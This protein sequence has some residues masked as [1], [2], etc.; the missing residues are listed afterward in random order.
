MI[1]P[2]DIV[3]SINA[4]DY[5]KTW[6]HRCKRKVNAGPIGGR[7]TYEFTPTGVGVIVLA[8]CMCGWEKNLT[9][10]ESF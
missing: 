3:F 10:Y 5:Q 7:M 6:K 9:D 2:A 4:K 8:K 1:T